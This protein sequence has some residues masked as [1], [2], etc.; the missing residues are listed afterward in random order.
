VNPPTIKAAIHEVCQRLSE[1]SLMSVTFLGKP[2]AGNSALEQ[3]D[4][5]NPITSSPQ[6][7][8]KRRDLLLLTLLGRGIGQG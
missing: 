6:T 1:R 3:P 8:A 7:G 2:N 5:A 4:S